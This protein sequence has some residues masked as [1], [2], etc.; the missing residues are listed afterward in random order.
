MSLNQVFAPPRAA[1]H[2]PQFLVIQ[3]KDAEHVSL[4][5]SK[6]EACTLDNQ[7]KEQSQTQVVALHKIYKK[8]ERSVMVHA[9]F[10]WLILTNLPRTYSPLSTFFFCSHQSNCRS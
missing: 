4:K 3:G 8:K 7:R 2:W 1:Q 5:E 10:L 9:E 6:V